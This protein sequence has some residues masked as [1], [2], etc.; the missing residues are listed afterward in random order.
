MPARKPKFRW[1]D[2]RVPASLMVALVA[3]LLLL[4]AAFRE[5]PLSGGA[6]EIPTSFTV[7]VPDNITSWAEFFACYEI[8]DEEI[9][10][11]TLANSATGGD[12]SPIAFPG[13]EITIWL[14]DGT[15]SPKV[16]PR[17]LDR[18]STHANARTC[19]PDTRP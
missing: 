16:P 19:T 14:P 6:R 15:R 7:K 8:T 5:A 18:V 13:G 2:V 12:G 1:R 17:F 10:K 11:R 4:A 9:I 3:S